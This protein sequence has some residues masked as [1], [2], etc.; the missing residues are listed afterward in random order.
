MAMADFRI[1]GAMPVQGRASDCKMRKHNKIVVKEAGLEIQV[2]SPPRGIMIPKVKENHTFVSPY[3]IN[4]LVSRF[5]P[6]CSRYTIT[7]A[8][9]RSSRQL[10]KN[11]LWRRKR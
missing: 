6:M 3:Q 8:R 4:I 9:A 10:L 2:V 1:G 5:I 11:I 7:R